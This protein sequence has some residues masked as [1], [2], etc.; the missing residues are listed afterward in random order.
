MSDNG[1][2]KIEFIGSVPFSKITVNV[3]NRNYT[4]DYV[5]TGVFRTFQTPWA[6]TPDTKSF[7]IVAVE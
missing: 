2:S 7:S 3:N 1:A 4:F 5:K 6:F